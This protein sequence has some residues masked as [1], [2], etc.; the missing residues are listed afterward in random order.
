MSS[1]VAYLRES[2]EELHHVRWPTHQQA[3]RLSLVV[4][5]F[6]VASALAFGI[7]DFVLAEIITFILPS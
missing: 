5:V 7:T 1:I 4:L 3:I 2:I 6:T